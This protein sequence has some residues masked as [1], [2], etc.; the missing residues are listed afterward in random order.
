VHKTKCCEAEKKGR[1]KC[2]VA[3][4]GVTGSGEMWME[5]WGKD[6][7]VVEGEGEAWY[8]GCPDVWLGKWDQAQK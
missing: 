7:C 3:I 1:I 6:G 8:C 5:R 4:V 2:D